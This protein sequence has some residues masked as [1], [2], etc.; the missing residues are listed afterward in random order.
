MDNS[1]KQ[2][3]FCWVDLGTIGVE[4]SKKFYSGLFGWNAIDTPADGG[5]TYTMMMLDEKA[6]SAVYEMNEEVKSQNIPPHWISYVAVD[7]VDDT[8]SKVSGLGGN[9]IMEPFDVMEEG[10]MGLLADPTGAIIALWQAKNNIGAAVKNVPGALCWFEHASND[11]S[12]AIP[13]LEKLL[14]WTS[15]TQKMGEIEYTTFFAGEEMAAGM[16]KMP[17]EMDGVPAHWLPYFLVEDVDSSVAKA[18]AG[19]ANILRPNTPIPN[20]GYFAV[21]QDPQGAAFAIFQGLEG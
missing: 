21:I 8:M 13:F 20:M 15:Q 7:S 4:D 9:V 14:G 1:Y 6:V 3:I 12:A 17:P 11:P 2:G 18:Q 5:L 16:F 10:R 19:G